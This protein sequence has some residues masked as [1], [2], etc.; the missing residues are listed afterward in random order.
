MAGQIHGHVRGIDLGMVPIRLERCSANKSQHSLTALLPDY[1][2][3][4]HTLWGG[5]LGM[6]TLPIDPRTTLTL[7]RAY[8]L[9]HAY[10]HVRTLIHFIRVMI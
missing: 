10:V 2:L 1:T 5:E 3:V 7:M 9:V 4:L 8:S 6:G